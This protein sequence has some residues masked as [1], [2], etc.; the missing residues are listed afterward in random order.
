MSLPLVDLTLKQTPT[1]ADW[2]GFF[3]TIINYINAGIPVEDLKVVDGKLS[4]SI[5]GDA[6]TLNGMTAAEIVG[7]D[8]PDINKTLIDIIGAGLVL[9][10][11]VATKDINIPTKLNITAIRAVQKIT[12]SGH[13]NRVEL[14]AKAVSTVLPNVTYYLDLPA[15]GLDYS[16]AS[17]HYEGDY[18]PIAE[19]TTNENAEISTVSQTMKPSRMTMLDGLDAKLSIANAL[20]G[21]INQATTAQAMTSATSLA[22]AIS[23]IVNRIAAITG[24]DNWY[25]DPDKTIAQ[26]KE[27]VNISI[28]DAGDKTA[29]TTVEG[30]I[31]ELY[32][33]VAEARTYA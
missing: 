5:S 3:N 29:E 25:Q 4:V 24:K 12:A 26:L 14:G 19:V 28:A 17:D 31:Q 10:G 11:G 13:I 30:A 20:I 21:T 1:V 9:V 7:G 15:G 16:F 22:T 32:A 18:I 23:Y 8:F 6:G 2:E 33:K 27:A